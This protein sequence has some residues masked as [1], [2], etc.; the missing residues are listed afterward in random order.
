M[1]YF[2]NFRL[3]GTRHLTVHSA[4]ASDGYRLIVKYPDDRQRVH[5][6]SDDTSLYQGTVEV[7]A[8]LTHKGWQPCRP[9]SGDWLSHFTR[10]QHFPK[11]ARI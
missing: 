3:G 11:F 5:H 9:A 6:F 4:R 10:A 7:Q 2:S 8:A 1:V